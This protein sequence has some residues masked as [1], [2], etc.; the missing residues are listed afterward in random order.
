MEIIIKIAITALLIN[1]LTGWWG[2]KAKKL[3][4][5]EITKE[6]KESYRTVGEIFSATSV[7][8]FVI[9]LGSIIAGIWVY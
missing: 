2:G 6:K 1:I 8:A 7:V 5:E 4:R 9:L 3:G